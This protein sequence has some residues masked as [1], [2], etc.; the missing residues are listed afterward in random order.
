[1][2]SA[3]AYPLPVKNA[4][5]ERAARSILAKCLHGS[6]RL[7]KSLLG[8]LLIAPPHE[9]DLDFIR[10]VIL[11]IQHSEEQAFGVVLDR[12]TPTKVRQAWQGRSRC[13]HDEFVYTGGPVSSPLIALQTEPFLG[14]IEV[15]P[16]VYYSVQKGHLE[17]LLRYPMH[18]LRWSRTTSAGGRINWN[19]SWKTAI[20]EHCL[21]P[22][23]MSSTPGRTFGKS[24]DARE[25]M[26]PVEWLELQRTA[27]W[28]RRQAEFLGRVQP[29]EAAESEWWCA[30]HWKNC[31]GTKRSLSV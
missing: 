13:Q 14:E 6:D 30:K 24:V 28:S 20:G 1:M 17:Q 29:R 7:M 2:T 15:L 27:E 11:L 19:D 18:S 31:M 21:R 3:D 16:G 23:S 10:T 4:T 12:P 5:V 25:P 9:R 22:V 26:K 8:H